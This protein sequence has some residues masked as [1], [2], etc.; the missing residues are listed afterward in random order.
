[1]SMGFTKLIP[2]AM[3]M[4][5]ASLTAA[6]VSSSSPMVRG[7]KVVPGLDCKSHPRLPYSTDLTCAFSARG[8]AVHVFFAAPGADLKG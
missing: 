1:M 8:S 2:G 6:N 7:A 5:N 3:T 4:F